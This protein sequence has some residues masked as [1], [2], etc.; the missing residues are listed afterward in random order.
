MGLEAALI[1]ALAVDIGRLIDETLVCSLQHRIA[2]QIA[3]SKRRGKGAALIAA[4]VLVAVR[5]IRE[6]QE[7]CGS[8][9]DLQL[10]R[11]W[12]CA[13]TGHS[14]RMRKCL[15]PHNC[16]TVLGA[17]LQACRLEG[18]P[19]S[20]MSGMTFELDTPHGRIMATML[21]GIAQFESDLLGERVKSG[22]AAARA[23]GKETRPS[24]RP[25][26]Q[27]RPA[28]SEGAQCQRRREELPLDRPAISASAT[29]NTVTDIVKRHRANP[30]Q[31]RISPP[32]PDS[33][34]SVSPTAAGAS[35]TSSRSSGHRASR[36]SCRRRWQRS[37][38][39]WGTR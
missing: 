1:F 7:S 19:W 28:C 23:R 14:G 17:L 35:T 15:L 39:R 29:N 33:T 34:P 16:H 18:C 10:S 11:A 31:R 5:R 4:L 36:R 26:S 9:A 37:S 20:P 13:R 27:A 12:E 24:A 2:P 8:Q 30:H 21:A 22:L 25:A 6:H 32:L 38:M 3:A